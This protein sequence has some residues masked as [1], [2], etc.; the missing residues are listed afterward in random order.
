MTTP[1]PDTAAAALA[2]LEGTP[3]TLRALAAG[4]PVAMLLRAGEGEWSARD[5][6][7]HLWMNDAIALERFQRITDEDRPAIANVD[8]EAVLTG[9]RGHAYS[10]ATLLYRVTMG[11]GALTRYLRTLSPEQL[12]HT[13][14]HSMVGT[15][16][17]VELLHH[18]AYHDLNHVR[19]IAA[20]IAEPLDEHRGPLRVF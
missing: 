14:E 10:V 18:L 4:V 3:G 2:I 1:T 5:V 9:S 11:R 20:L 12:E 17:S 7:V 16:S 19:Q 15:M 13:G 8:E 6:L